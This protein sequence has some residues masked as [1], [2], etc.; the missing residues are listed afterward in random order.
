MDYTNIL[1]LRECRVIVAELPQHRDGVLAGQTPAGRPSAAESARICVQNRPGHRARQVDDGD[2][3]ELF[4]RSGAN[5]TPTETG[6][7]PHSLV[8]VENTI[9]AIT[10]LTH[11]KL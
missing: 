9:F 5:S 7:E 11:K 4:H 2:T 8:L 1:P 3:G 6:L 10:V